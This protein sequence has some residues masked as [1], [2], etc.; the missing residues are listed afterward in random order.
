V[1]GFPALGLSLNTSMRVCLQP[2]GEGNWKIE[3]VQKEDREKILEVLDLLEDLS[4][5]PPSAPR[6]S[7]IVRLESD[8]PR[9]LGFGSSASLC[10]A[11]AA[12]VASWR[13]GAEKRQI[14]EWAHRGEELFHGTP[15]GIDTGLALL[16]G[17][18]SF[19]PH[20]PRLPA[21]RRLTGIPLHL[22]VGAVPRKQSAGALIRTLRERMAGGD[23]EAG[24]TLR[25]LDRLAEQAAEILNGGPFHGR[26]VGEA[27]AHGVGRHGRQERY[28]LRRSGQVHGGEEPAAALGA[29]ALEAQE[30]LSRLGLN[31]PE[32]E[33]LLQEGLA[34]GALGG[35]LSGAG[36]G[37]AFFLIYPDR[38]SALSAA[39]ELRKLSREAGLPTA[40][41]I[42]ALA[43]RP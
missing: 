27:G 37:G 11:L 8:I 24:K 13:G 9:G 10:V 18:Y 36:G 4:A 31:T 5:Q 1:Y 12:A 34:R 25:R 6:G 28:S 39:S 2:A 30:N 14:W 23:E 29:L 41:T 35:K 17:L 19:R 32:L 40:E 43:W 33:R 7:F 20:P 15:S 16:D 42:H 26:E 22:V 21:A 3:G 38:R